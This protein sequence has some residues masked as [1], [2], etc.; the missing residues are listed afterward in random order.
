MARVYVNGMKECDCL[1]GI[2]KMACGI[3]FVKTEPMEEVYPGKA[4]VVLSSG[5]F[6][7]LLT[8]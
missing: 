5:L 2:S 4:R 3:D 1:F 7:A 6:T 8:G